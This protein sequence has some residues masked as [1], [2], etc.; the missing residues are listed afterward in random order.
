[1]T[2]DL[3]LKSLKVILF[4]QLLVEAMDDIRNSTLYKGKVK[5]HANTLSN[6]LTPMLKFQVDE[7]YKTDPELTTNLF[8]QLDGLIKKLAEMNV[9]SLTMIN[10]IHDHYSKHPEDWEN[11]FALEMEKLQD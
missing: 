4:S 2:D 10:Q 1:M 11:F 9:V 7:V 3:K 5:Q 8:N 6:I